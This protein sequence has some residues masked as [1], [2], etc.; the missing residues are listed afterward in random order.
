MTVSIFCF[1]A[2]FGSV[3]C[4]TNCVSNRCMF[5]GEAV[6]M[7][8]RWTLSLARQ[9][10]APQH[11]SEVAINKS[12]FCIAARQRRVQP[13]PFCATKLRHAQNEKISAE[14]PQAESPPKTSHLGSK[15]RQ[16]P[17]YIC[18]CLCAERDRASR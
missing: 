11:K 1:S 5:S 10:R 18:T 4:S 13:K 15:K 7:P 3:K 2:S 12:T 6:T 14:D 16:S 17:Y 8:T 9:Y